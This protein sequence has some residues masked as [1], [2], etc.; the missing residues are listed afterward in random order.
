MAKATDVPQFRPG[1]V[2][3]SARALN[4]ILGGAQLA[5]RRRVDQVQPQRPRQIVI[6]TKA[7]IDAGDLGNVQITGY[8]ASTGG[9]EEYG[10]EFE[11][12]NLGPANVPAGVRLPLTMG[13]ASVQYFN[14]FTSAIDLSSSSS[15]SVS[16]TSSD[17]YPSSDTSDSSDTTGSSESSASSASSASSGGGGGGLSFTG[18]DADSTGLIADRTWRTFSGP[19]ADTKAMII[20]T[21]STGYGGVF[22][23][24]GGGSA[25][26]GVSALDSMN[27]VVVPCDESG[28]CEYYVDDTSGTYTAYLHGYWH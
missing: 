24:I 2:D 6:I 16:S 28:E 1:Q 9:F 25:T 18:V 12:L 26:E 22:W 8:D 19:T 7:A 17:T 15:S 5:E 21:Y 4:A 13:E 20:K 23:R 14:Y 10:D 11:A 27:G 3:L